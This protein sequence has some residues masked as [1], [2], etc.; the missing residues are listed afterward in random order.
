M[1][2]RR[3]LQLIHLELDLRAA[4]GEMLTVRE[5]AQEIRLKWPLREWH[6][7]DQFA[8]EEFYLHQTIRGALREPLSEDYRKLH[9]PHV[10]E[11]YRQLV[12]EL[13]AWFFV[14]TEMRWVFSL[15][16]TPEHWDA[17]AE[18]RIEMAKRTA[19][20]AAPYQEKAEILRLKCAPTLHELLTRK[21]AA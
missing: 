21:K 14:M 2:D 9:L 13:N 5:V 18:M 20:M 11:E 10:P 1:A 8:A 16:A 19:A 6:P 7:R 4:R 3:M 15:N 12:G 17:G